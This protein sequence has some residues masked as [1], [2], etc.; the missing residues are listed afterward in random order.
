MI[1][2]THAHVLSP[3]RESYPYG[4]LRGGATP[5]VSP[6]VFPVEELVR[7]MDAC[8]IAHA[9]LVQRA[10]LYGYDNRYV[11]NAAARFAERLAP[12]VVLDAQEPDSA[13]KLKRLAAGQRLAG[14]RLVAPT[15][16]A[17][18]TAWL[19]SAP[20]LDFWAAAADLQ[21]PVT[22]ILYRL[23]NAA[24]RSAL[25]RV[26]R[27]FP[28][29]PILVDHVGLPH[30]STPEKKWGEAHGHD[31]SIPGGPD[32]GVTEHLAELGA[33]PHVH[34]KVT[35]INFDRLEEAHLDAAR[36]VRSLADAFGA[37][38]LLWGSDV[39]Q[40]PAPY[41]EK[42]ARLQ[43]SAQLLNETERSAF[44]GGTAKRLY[45]AALGGS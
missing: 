2:D 27:R 5:P 19:D 29:L 24:G 26:A 44:L 14:L 9:C 35:D 21:L 32:F 42:V 17:A 7:Q 15:L 11:L 28:T 22:V 31:Y 36:F 20:V 16:S 12:V 6:V 18:D 33:L 10:T 37:D 41:A 39:G 1:F 34:F 40:S 45:G 25:L 8:G 13:R 23:N 3:D 4:T 43:Q 30:A 38:R